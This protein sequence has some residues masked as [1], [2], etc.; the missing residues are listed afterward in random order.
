MSQNPTS[1]KTDLKQVPALFK[2]RGQFLGPVNL[3]I[4]GGAGE[5]GTDYLQR[6]HDVMNIVYDPFNRSFC[7][8]LEDLFIVG[9]GNA[10]TVTICNVLNVI[11]ERKYRLRVLRLA[12][13]MCCTEGTIYI[14]IYEGSKTGKPVET[15]KGWQLNAPANH[16]KYRDDIVSLFGENSVKLEK[17]IYTIER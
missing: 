2:T 6:E 15:V 5:A 10:D 12:K 16:W 14:Q 17:N 1:K 4:G 9:R 8:N 11:K 13:V 3:D 7:E